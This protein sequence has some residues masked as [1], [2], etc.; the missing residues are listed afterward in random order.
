MTYIHVSNKDR[1]KV[2]SQLDNLRMAGEWKRI[3]WRSSTEGCICGPGLDILPIGQ[4][5][6]P[7]WVY[8][9]I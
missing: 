3:R 8:Y 6:Q 5:I 7:S 4:V 2:K 9:V 1:S